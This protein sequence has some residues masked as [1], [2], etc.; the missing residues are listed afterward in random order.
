MP[1]IVEVKNV[2]KSYQRDSL[3]IPVLENIN[4]NVPE[5]EF[6][7]LMGPSGSGKSTLLNLIAGIDRPDGGRG[8]IMV[9]NDDVTKLTESQLANWRSRHV[10]FIFQFYNLMPVLTAFENVEL[11]LLLTHLSKSERHERVKIALNVVGLSDRMRHY[12]KQLSGGQQQ[13]VAIARAIVADPTL[14][15]ADE[16]T[17]DL[18][19]NS[20]VEILS[21]LERLNKEFN[22]TIIMVTHDQRAAEKAHTVR[23]LDKG[24]LV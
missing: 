18:D 21:L 19:K 7:A 1:N 3:K 23:H 2:S 22:K 24:E 13:R 16:P 11:P 5:G 14:I 12:P 9:A 15:V 10:G 20:A 4:L 6:L 8:S 17:G